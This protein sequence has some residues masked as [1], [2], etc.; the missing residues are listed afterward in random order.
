MTLTKWVIIRLRKVMVSKV[1]SVYVSHLDLSK[2]NMVSNDLRV[3]VLIR[4]GYGE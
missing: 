2:G 4:R 1:L 3:D